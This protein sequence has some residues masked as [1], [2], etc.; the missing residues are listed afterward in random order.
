ME[1]GGNGRVHDLQRAHAD[2]IATLATFRHLPV[3]SLQDCTHNFEQLNTTLPYPVVASLEDVGEN[4][5]ALGM[6]E[7]IPVLSL[8][9]AT[10]N[11]EQLTG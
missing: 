3:T 10:R 6:G 4:F 2:R 1:T 8:Q 11:F 9:D 7:H 5:E